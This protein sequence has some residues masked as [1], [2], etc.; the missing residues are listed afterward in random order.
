[1]KVLSAIVVDSTGSDEDI[2]EVDVA[3]SEAESSTSRD[4]VE[5]MSSVL[6]S[7]P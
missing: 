1:M 4:V 7:V 2:S 3:D 6:D 5:V